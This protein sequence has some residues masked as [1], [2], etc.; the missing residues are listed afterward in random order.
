MVQLFVDNRIFLNKYLLRTSFIASVE[1]LN[2]GTYIQAWIDTPGP[3]HKGHDR[4]RYR[5]TYGL[6]RHNS[7]GIPKREKWAYIFVLRAIITIYK[8]YIYIIYI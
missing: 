5:G 3:K 8:R 6:P 1:N 7:T 4:R 2:S